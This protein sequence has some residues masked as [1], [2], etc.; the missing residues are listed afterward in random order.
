MAFVQPNYGYLPYGYPPAFNPGTLAYVRRRM[1]EGYNL[2]VNGEPLYGEAALSYSANLLD[3]NSLEFEINW[4][5][6][7]A[8]AK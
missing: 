2:V 5:W 8:H 7:L 3:V 4:N 1:Q 6:R